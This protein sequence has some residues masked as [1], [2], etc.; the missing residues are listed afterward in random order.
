MKLRKYALKGPFQSREPFGAI[1]GPF[2]M[3][4]LPLLSE[5]LATPLRSTPSL[6]I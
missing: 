3:P 2:K 1:T 6:L 5:I 4:V